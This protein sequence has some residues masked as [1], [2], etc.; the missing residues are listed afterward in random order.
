MKVYA[1]TILLGGI[2]FSARA[3][4]PDLKVIATAGTSYQVENFHLDW[5]LGES[6]ILTLENSS[7][8]LTQGF[9]QSTYDIISA[10][11]QPEWIE[12][13]SAFP[14]PVLDNLNIHLEFSTA[15]HGILALLDMTGKCVWKV[16]FAGAILEKRCNTSALPSGQ[17]WI[18]VAVPDKHEDQSISVI[19]L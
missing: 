10:V 16:S 3:Q 14:N 11:E 19:K 8:L 2:I 13:F 9:H 18:N 5:T 12:K 17:Y 4:T 7:L 15:E 1:L 6:V